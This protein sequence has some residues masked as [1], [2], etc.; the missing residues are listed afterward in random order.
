[1]I[2]S[3]SE[4]V[5]FAIC[6]VMRTSPLVLGALALGSLTGA[7]LFRRSRRYNFV[8]RNALVTGGSRGLGLEI[9]R[10][11]VERG[12]SVAIV[13]RDPLEM[14]RA[15][16][17]L[18]PRATRKNRVIGVLCDLSDGGSISEMLNTVR[19]QLGPIDVLVNNAGAIQVGPLDAMKPEDFENEMRLHCFAPMRTMLGVRDDMRRRGGGR[20]ANIA[21]IGG[22]IS[23]PH[24]LP[25]SASKFAL[26]GLSQ[27]MHAE[28]ARDEIV[29]STIVPGLMRTGSPPNATFKGDHRREYAWF[30]VSDSLPLI[31]MSS[32]RAATQVVEAMEYGKPY[33]VLGLS[34]KIA[35]FAN[36][37]FPGLVNRAMTLVT[38]LLPQ[39]ANPKS[40]LGREAGS[41]LSNSFLTA[42]TRRAALRNNEC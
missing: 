4:G 5:P 20:I 23:V 29:V 12:S 11:L 34:A 26:V 13:A 9:A 32:R 25:Y 16:A 24:L 6:A 37:L 30:S 42:A 7:A 10:V 2:S 8:H 35:A 36:G 22:V 15:L 17:D 3:A 19:V 27:G 41:P 39:S 38:A 33:V 18:V 28:L 14:E 21:S 31:S 1:M 40:K